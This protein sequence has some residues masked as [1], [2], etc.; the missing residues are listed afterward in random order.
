MKCLKIKLKIYLFQI[1]AL[2]QERWLGTVELYLPDGTGDARS[3]QDRWHWE[4]VWSQ[5]RFA[6]R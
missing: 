1:T 3:L 2:E 4:G 6:H 5:V